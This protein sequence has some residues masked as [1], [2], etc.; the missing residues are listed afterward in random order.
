MTQKT[1]VTEAIPA[2]AVEM[3]WTNISIYTNVL[4]FAGLANNWGEP[5]I[6]HDNA[7][8]DG[9]AFLASID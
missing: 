2:A 4:N 6:D 1:R 5:H 3:N 7:E 8:E 9:Q